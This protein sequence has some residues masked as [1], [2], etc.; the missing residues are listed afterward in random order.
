MCVAWFARVLNA[1]L[2]AR[3]I[4]FVVNNEL[5]CHANEQKPKG[6]EVCL[7]NDRND[8]DAAFASEIRLPLALEVCWW[9]VHQHSESFLM[10]FLKQPTWNPFPSVS[11]CFTTPKNR[12]KRATIKC[13]CEKK[14][15]KGL[16]A[17]K[18]NKT[19][20]VVTRK[21]EFRAPVEFIGLS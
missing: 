10:D 12:T 14:R 1:D 21:K 2:L 11:D 7:D 13:E 15:L 3:F 16:R 18:I 8:L 6:P 9:F 19:L 4:I 17:I 5:S 20:S